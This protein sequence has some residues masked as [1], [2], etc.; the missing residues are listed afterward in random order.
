MH[1]NQSTYRQIAKATSLFGGVQA[2]Q[3]II[4]IIKSKFVA[5]L[6]GPTGMGIVG[7]FTSTIGLITSI[8]NFGLGTSAVRDISEANAT[9]DQKRI[10]TVVTVIRKLVWAT[11]L[12]GAIITLVLS[13]ILSQIAFGS[14]E[15]TI[16]F[17]WLS[18]TLLLNQLSTGQLV[19]LQ[20]LRRLN[21]LAKAQL[22]GSII[23]LAVT[24]P[25]Y[26]IFGIKGIVPVIII[27][28]A[29]A[30]LLT[31]HYSRK[32]TV[33]K[34]EVTN[35]MVLKEGKSM[36]TMGIMI[37]LTEILGLLFGY[38]I[39][40]YIT[41][42]GGISEMGFF[43]AGFAII[44]T[45][46]SL[47]FSALDADFYPR[48]SAVAKNNLAAKLTINQQGEVAILILAPIL[49]LF[50]VF[51]RWAIII[52]YSSEFLAIYG[53]LQWAALG[54]FFRTI[55]WAIS[56]LFVS[57][58]AGK[59][60]FWSEFVANSYILLFYILG[61]HYGGLTGIGI[62]HMVSYL[63]YTIQVFILTK[64]KYEFSFTSSF[65]KIFLILF[66]IASICS[67]AV[68]I[69]IEPINYIIGILLIA[70]ASWYSYKELNKL[71]GIRDL[72]QNFIHNKKEK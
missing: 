3:I 34:T 12:L 60:F 42:T 20:G 7:L 44:N 50:L 49:I 29:T 14:K 13:P 16:A 38:I 28:S 2:F 59:I 68:N 25:I 43:T 35:R 37:S 10:S 52:L 48:L 63:I 56:L 41:N 61:Y 69:T 67:I 39:R 21:D 51:V 15:Y 4:T 57:K 53:M 24:I 72:V 70:L 58:G 47:I 33:V 65:I 45:Y 32:I 8:T 30:L 62:A 55:S 9:Q 64:T 17:I 66:A 26:Y 11:G 46:V 6:I 31:W 71:I 5:I 18:A 27:T 36:M 54:V 22:W 40:I 1:K 23:G 19:L